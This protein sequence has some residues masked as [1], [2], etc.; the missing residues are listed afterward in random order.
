[1]S[2]SSNYFSRA[3]IGIGVYVIASMG[4]YVYSQQF[5]NVMRI[6][7]IEIPIFSRILMGPS[8]YL[9]LGDAPGLYVMASLICVPAIIFGCVRTGLKRI[10]AIAMGVIIWSGFGIIFS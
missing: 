2:E 1:M 9:G 3:I 4:G 10:I 8:L 5:L 7:E 6:P